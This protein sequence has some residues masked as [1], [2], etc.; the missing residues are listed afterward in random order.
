MVSAW[1]IHKLFRGWYL[2]GGT[3]DR[4]GL[5]GLAVPLV[6]LGLVMLVATIV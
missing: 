2:A 4:W 1:G 6:D 5:L 3:I